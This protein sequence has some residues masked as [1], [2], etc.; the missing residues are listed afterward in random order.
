M[1]LTQEQIKKLSQDLTKIKN[2]DPKLAD[3]VNNIIKY[4][5]LLDEVD[6]RWVKPTVSVVQQ[7]NTLRKDEITTKEVQPMDLLKC[8]KQKVVAD[9]IAVSNIMK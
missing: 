2:D 1:T 4:M 5:D 9:Q 7:E 8:S 6:T 3:D